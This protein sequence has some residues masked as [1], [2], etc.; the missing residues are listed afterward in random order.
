MA[1][2]QDNSV[3]FSLNQLLDLHEETVRAEQGVYR[4]DDGIASMLGAVKITRGQNQLNGCSAEVNLN[5]G[6]SKLFGCS[7]GSQG[8]QVGG[9]IHPRRTPEGDQPVP[10]GEPGGRR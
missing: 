1:A 2:T 5:T 4:V 8:G 6:I 3:L 7:G 10:L 9:L